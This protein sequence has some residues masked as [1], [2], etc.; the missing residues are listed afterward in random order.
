MATQVIVTDHPLAQHKLTL[1]RRVETATPEF[2]VL[3]R[4]GIEHF[5]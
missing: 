4:E 5:H 2:R 1:I 3:L